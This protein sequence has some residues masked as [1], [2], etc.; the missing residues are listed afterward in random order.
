MYNQET[1]K[2]LG[3]VRARVRVGQFLSDHIAYRSLALKPFEATK[4]NI[5]RK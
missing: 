2:S 3:K 5:Y 1:V 4:K